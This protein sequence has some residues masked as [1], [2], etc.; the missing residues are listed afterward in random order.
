MLNQKGI[1][2]L[3]L[4]LI[5]LI[6]IIVTVFLVGKTQIFKPKASAK[7][8]E[9]IAATGKDT[10][11]K[12]CSV[13]EINAAGTLNTNCLTVKIKFT[14]PIDTT[15]VSDAGDV[16]V[17]N[18]YALSD[19]NYYCNF[20]PNKSDDPNKFK[21]FYKSCDLILNLCALP[22]LK[23]FITEKFEQC[24][25]SQQ[26]QAITTDL[27]NSG[28]R[29]AP[30]QTQQKTAGNFNPQVI[31]RSTTTSAPKPSTQVLPSSSLRGGTA[32][33]P[34]PSFVTALQQSRTLAQANPTPTP[35]PTPTPITSPSAAATSNPSP[36]SSPV[37]SFSPGTSP[38]GV[39]TTEPPAR[40]TLYFRFAENESDFVDSACS[41]TVSYGCWQNYTKGGSSVSY[42]FQVK[43]Y[44]QKFIFA[45]FKDN[46]G[47]IYKESEVH[48]YPAQIITVA[49]A[50]P[51]P[52]PS[53]SASASEKAAVPQKSAE[54]AASSTPAKESGG[55]N[56]PADIGNEPNN[57]AL[58]DNCNI[59]QLSKLSNGR[60]MTFPAYI[61]AQ[62][63]NN[64]L[65]LF[66]NED[67]IKI[68][69][70]SEGRTSF[71]S[72]FS[73]NDLVS[74]S[75]SSDILDLEDCSH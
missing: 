17:E 58:I 72:H 24:D 8:V 19:Q 68:A 6:G 15:A 35:T 62:F 9:F 70:N 66:S 20:D 11:G 43:A 1:A 44:G 65:L 12:A 67:L 10:Q 22:F 63:P 14:S 59:T 51:S 45:Q 25:T 49:P 3:F 13:T 41:T 48:P 26:C 50:T 64:R 75:F 4:I 46:Y 37:S 38:A 71:F 42:S 61:L 27:F 56:C 16:L 23:S 28:A 52:S 29:C 21:R 33:T 31:T 30:A 7:N 39:G 53:P 36:S 5:L 2:H 40:L 32:A 47:K 34:V 60:L 57:Q 18:A 73:C 55:A 74:H 69:D 54:P